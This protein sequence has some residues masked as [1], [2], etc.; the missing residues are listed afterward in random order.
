MDKTI[1]NTHRIPCH[2]G[3]GKRELR[4][5]QYQDVH[6]AVKLYKKKSSDF[7]KC[8]FA[9]N[10]SSVFAYSLFTAEFIVPETILSRIWRSAR[11]KSPKEL[12]KIV[13]LVCNPRKPIVTQLDLQTKSLLL[14]KETASYHSQATSKDVSVSDTINSDHTNTSNYSK[15]PTYI[16]ISP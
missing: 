7:A 2:S 1:V 13:D 5:D 9:P 12:I 14:N 4:R 8:L 3:L 16:M 15:L 6:D 10:I 11:K